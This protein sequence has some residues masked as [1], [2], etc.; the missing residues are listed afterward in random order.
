V[1]K[2]MRRSFVGGTAC[3]EIQIFADAA[4][5]LAR[6][7][8]QSLSLRPFRLTVQTENQAKITATAGARVVRSAANQNKTSAL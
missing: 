6:D 7:L 4:S 5:L 2:V 8:E 1:E 3:W